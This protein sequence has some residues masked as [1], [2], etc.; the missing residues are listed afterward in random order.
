[1]WFSQSP[2]DLH[3]CPPAPVVGRACAFAISSVLRYSQEEPPRLFSTITT[4]TTTKQDELHIQTGSISCRI[5]S[6]KA[7]RRSSSN[8]EHPTRTNPTNLATRAVIAFQQLL[9][10]LCHFSPKN[11]SISTTAASKQHN[12]TQ[13]ASPPTISKP[14]SK[15]IG[16][17]ISQSQSSQLNPTPAAS[18]ST[19]AYN[20]F[21]KKTRWAEHQLEPIHHQ[22]EANQKDLLSSNLWTST[23][24]QSKCPLPQMNK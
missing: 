21:S 4:I 15:R 9:A 2:L 24:P 19:E 3:L 18:N 17:V 22:A 7:S 5:P 1:M 13:Q 20:G 11:T 6:N 12:A 16:Q 8:G 10:R 23:S 14:R